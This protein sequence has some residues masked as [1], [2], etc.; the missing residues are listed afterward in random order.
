MPEK[1]EVTEVTVRNRF[2]ELIENLNIDI[3]SI[4]KRFS[5]E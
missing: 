5:E 1:D 3:A 4:K 2:S